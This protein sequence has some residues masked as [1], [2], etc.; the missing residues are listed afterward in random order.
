MTKWLWQLKWA[1]V[2]AIF[3]APVFALWSFNDSNRI[4]YLLTQ[5]DDILARVDGARVHHRR[6]G[7]DYAL[8][9]AWADEE[10]I[11]HRATVHISTAY[12]TSIIDGDA[13]TIDQERIRYLPGTV[14]R[15]VVVM[16]DVANELDG[17]RFGVWLGVLAG[18]A[19]LLLAPLTFW[20][21]RRARPKDE[22]IDSMLARMRGGQQS[23]YRGNA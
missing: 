19:S 12:A 20:A 18:I 21:H 3:A 7:S 1:L 14:G 10:G 23:Y 8:K 13:V 2:F 15:S 22:D 4:Q 6:G 9:L 5:G 11:A 16:A 17:A